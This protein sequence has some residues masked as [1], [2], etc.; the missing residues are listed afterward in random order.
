MFSPIVRF[1]LLGNSLALAPR[2]EARD[3]DPVRYDRG[4]NLERDTSF[5]VWCCALRE[6]RT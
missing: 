5:K 4:R 6:K 3:G 1:S 2:P